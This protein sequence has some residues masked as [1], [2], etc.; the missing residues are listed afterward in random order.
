MEKEGR[1]TWIF[2]E[3]LLS[4]SMC[5]GGWEPKNGEGRQYLRAALCSC[6]TD[7]FLEREGNSPPDRLGL[8]VVRVEIA[9]LVSTTVVELEVC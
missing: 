1:M 3:G 2:P 9:Y 8:V 5:V 6:R 4:I 7:S